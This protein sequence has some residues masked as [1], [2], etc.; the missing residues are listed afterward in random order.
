MARRTVAEKCLPSRRPCQ[1]CFTASADS[2]S[3]SATSAAEA[4]H[5]RAQTRTAPM[6]RLTRASVSSRAA[7]RLL[8]RVVRLLD[9]HELFPTEVRREALVVE[10]QH[11]AVADEDV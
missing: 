9:A 3:A 2:G 10:E 6:S 5:A 8:L 7:P 1:R 4:G 11:R